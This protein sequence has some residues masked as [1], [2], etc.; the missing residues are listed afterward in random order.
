MGNIVG[1]KLIAIAAAAIWIA[2]ASPAATQEKTYLGNSACKDKCHEEIF[3]AWKA[4]KHATSFGNLLP[5]ER[6][7]GKKEAGLKPKTDYRGDK[8]CMP[9]HVTGWRDGGYSLETPDQ[10][11][12]GVGCESCHGP[13]AKWN[14]EHQRKDL[15]NR[16]RR[17]KQLGQRKPFGGKN[18]CAQC[19]EDESSPYK[20]R[21]P[22]GKKEWTEKKMSAS[23]HPIK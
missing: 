14:A 18:V 13:A 3:K 2:Q 11:L 15:E 10:D 23:Y 6:E 21:S 19:H 4:G 20:F 9:C 1:A 12:L 22:P 16:E 8:S 5:G 17:M 7:K